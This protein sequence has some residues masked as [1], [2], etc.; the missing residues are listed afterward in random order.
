VL[1]VTDSGG[2]KSSSVTL[3]SICDPAGDANCR[4]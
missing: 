3:V 1:T 4:R 2:R